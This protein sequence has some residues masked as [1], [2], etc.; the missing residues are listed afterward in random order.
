MS[1][2][3]FVQR[4]AHGDT[5]PMPSVVFHAVFGPHI[6][7]TEPERQFW[8]VQAPDGGEADIYADVEG[9][10]CGSLMINHFSNGDVL[11]L[12]VEFARQADA[13]IMPVGCPVLL[14]APAQHGHL[15]DELLSSCA[16]AVITNGHDINMAIASA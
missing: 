16:T 6:D 4:F 1:F 9:E 15:P 5:T 3:V 14:T 7:R 13:V 8:H 2:D 10:S 11:D 12:L